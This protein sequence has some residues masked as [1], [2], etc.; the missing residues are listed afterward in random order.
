MYLSSMN[1]AIYQPDPGYPFQLSPPAPTVASAQSGKLTDATAN[2]NPLIV[3]NLADEL[4][5]H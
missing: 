4:E 2:R 1:C 3:P 5:I